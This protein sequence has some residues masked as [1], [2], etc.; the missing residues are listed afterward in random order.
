METAEAAAWLE[1]H[2]GVRVYAPGALIFEQDSEAN[3]F[4]YLKSGLCQSYTTLKGGEERAMMTTWPGRFFG[5]STFFDGFIR[6]AST[7][8]IRR[9]EVVEVTRPAYE[10]CCAEFPEFPK[11]LLGALAWDVSALFEQMADSA[12]L[13]ADVKVARFLCKRIANGEYPPGDCIRLDYTQAF[14][15]KALGLSR[16]S[17]NL[18]LSGFRD[19]GW[20]DT[21]YGVIEVL[22]PDKLQVFAYGE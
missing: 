18:S 15:A 6:L 22:Q 8:A 1:A 19:D 16:V 10:A 11:L 12:L 4:Y 9:C 5:L 7:V 20:I 3:A 13:S 14:I 17:V 21:K 2:C